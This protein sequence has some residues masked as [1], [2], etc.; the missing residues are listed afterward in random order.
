MS[1]NL[2]NTVVFARV[3]PAMLKKQLKYYTFLATLL[4]N[5]ANIAISETQRQKTFKYYD[6]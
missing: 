1:N 3:R 6:F 4:E 2:A 5:L